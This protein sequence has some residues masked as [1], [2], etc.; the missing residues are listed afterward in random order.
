MNNHHVHLLNNHHVYLYHMQDTKPNLFGL[1][2]RYIY[3]FILENNMITY[4]P[5]LGVFI[6][7]GT[8]GYAQ[9]VRIFPNPPV[10]LH[11]SVITFWQSK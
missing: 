10:L 2:P 5:R 9:A 3:R 7:L 11:P 6:V 1:K 8:T 4:N